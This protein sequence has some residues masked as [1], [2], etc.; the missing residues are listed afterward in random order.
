[1][2]NTFILKVLRGE[3]GHQYWEE[4][5]LER[6]TTLNIIAALMEIQRN[7]YNRRGQK[8]APVVWEQSCLES[9]CG[10]CT[11]LVNGQP[12]QACSVMVEAFLKEEKLR[13]KA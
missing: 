7:P 1:M 8:V 3:S 10:S 9:I 6:Y 5:E 4:F 2:G 13:V 11:M 12:K